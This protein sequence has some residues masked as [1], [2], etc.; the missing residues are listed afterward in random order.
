[1]SKFTF[2]ISI[3][4][5]IISSCNQDETKTSI[6]K[7][8]STSP[9]FEVKKYREGVILLCATFTKLSNTQLT[10]EEYMQLQ[11]Q[12]EAIYLGLEFGVNAGFYTDEDILVV[13]D[14]LECVM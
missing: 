9:L 14:S 6:P 13:A 5:L 11:I 8:E 4:C 10:D 12:V 2:G 3:L 1:M 7:K